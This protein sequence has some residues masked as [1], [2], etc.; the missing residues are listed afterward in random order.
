[1]G[2]SPSS[3][4]DPTRDKPF[5]LLGCVLD[6]FDLAENLLDFSEYGY[7]RGD[8]T[9][10][11]VVAFVERLTKYGAALRDLREGEELCEEEEITRMW[12][13]SMCRDFV[14][15]YTTRADRFNARLRDIIAVCEASMPADYRERD[16]SVKKRACLEFTR[17]FADK[18][19]EVKDL[20]LC[21][22]DWRESYDRRCAPQVSVM[23]DE[24]R[25]IDEDNRRRE[26]ER[27]AEEE[28]YR[29]DQ[30]GHSS[31]RR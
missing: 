14:G 28:S 1:M 9:T 4:R 21:M 6:A 8:F 16:G 22:E 7:G 17:T 29:R 25:R 24:Q 19:E 30:H 5:K 3:E 13:G 12:P 15:W 11:T 31:R 10:E 23:R 20:A 2:P 18:R 26:E 27:R